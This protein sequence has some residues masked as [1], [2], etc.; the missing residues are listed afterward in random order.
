M[1]PRSQRAKQMALNNL[2]AIEHL[3]QSLPPLK[4]KKIEIK[5]EFYTMKEVDSPKT[6]LLPDVKKK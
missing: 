1:D 4:K 3:I 2:K 6:D 5:E